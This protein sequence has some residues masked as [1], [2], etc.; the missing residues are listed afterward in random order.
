MN[1]LPIKTETFYYQHLF[2]S[3]DNVNA[4]KNFSVSQKS[5]KGLE[6]YLKIMSAAEEDENFA[7]TYLVKDNETHEI[8]SYFTLKSGLFTLE[9]SDSQFYTVPSIELSNF[10]V[11]SSYRKHHPEV[12][13]IGKTTFRE[14]VLPLTKFIQT[15]LGAKALYIFALP[16]DKLI[17]YYQEMGF[18]R[19]SEEKEK[20]VHS[21]VKPKY[22][23][24]CVFM[25]QIL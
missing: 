15:F 8:A 1:Y 23:D 6:D 3:E 25:Y 21:H 5:G 19:L 22:D 9:L 4:I 12:S 14:F 16:E 10:A 24:G 11:N 13:E 7:R 2:D 17:E 20:Y 18:T